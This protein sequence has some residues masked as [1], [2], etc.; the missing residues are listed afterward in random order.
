[1]KPKKREDQSVNALVRLRRGDK[2]L[3]G[4]NV[5]TKYGAETEGKIIQRLT[6]LGIHSIYSHQTQTL[7]W[8]LGSAC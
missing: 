1:M 3:T 2:I 4:G 8:I 7:L 6:H 5:D